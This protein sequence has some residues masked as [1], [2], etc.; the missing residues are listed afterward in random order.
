MRIAASWQQRHIAG[1]LVIVLAAPF[2]EAASTQ[3]QLVASAQQTATAPATNS[4]SSDRA[5]GSA[6][7]VPSQ[8]VATPSNSTSSSV[9]DGNEEQSLATL[10][11]APQQQ[12][13][14]TSNPVGTAAAPYEKRTGIAASRPAG[15]V[16][17]PAKQKRSRSFLIRVGLIVGACVAVGTI[18]ALS[19]GSPSRP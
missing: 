14:G 13:N 7:K 8:P 18:V 17:A 16:V 2:A 19:A 10:P 4:Q 1:C 9:G 3:P 5:T 6:D 15:A 12:Q 11:S